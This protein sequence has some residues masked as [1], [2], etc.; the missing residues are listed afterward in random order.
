[1][2]K[3][4]L[5][6]GALLALSA[7]G[8]KPEREPAASALPAGETL[9][10]ASKEMADMKAVG[11]EIATR[12]QAEALARIPGVL[13]RLSVRAGDV[14]RKGQRIG[15]IVDSRLGF[16]TS[17][18]GAQLAAAQAEAARANADLAR[19]RDLYDNGVYAKA[20]LDQAV[21]AARAAD[22]QVAA[23]R[24]QQRQRQRRWP[25]CGPGARLRPRA[26]RG[27]SGGLGRRSRHVDRHRHRRPAG[28]A[29]DA[30]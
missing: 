10:L 12:D 17:A 8:D 20:R 23:A 24:A 1:M 29:T 27:H 21:A 16:E 28:L 18:Y 15:M 13:T 14:V 19:I 6:A 11:A 30:A 5:L 25:G 7:C 22:A 9:R 2:G 3:W 4:F 26:A